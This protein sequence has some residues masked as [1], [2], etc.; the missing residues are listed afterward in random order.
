MSDTSSSKNISS[1]DEKVL[2]SIRPSRIVLPTIIGLAVIVWLVSRQL[3]LQELYAIK[4]Q[5]AAFT[6]ILIAIIV[7]VGRHLLPT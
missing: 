7:Y 5:A 6:W 4:W 2:D 3:D 1:S